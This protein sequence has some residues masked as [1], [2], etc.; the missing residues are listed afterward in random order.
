MPVYP[1]IPCRATKAAIQSAVERYAVRIGFRPGGDIS[2]TV[3]SLGGRIIYRD[4]FI[5]APGSCPESIHVRAADDFDIFVPHET[6][7]SRDRFTIAHE[8]GHLFLHYPAV[9][10]RYSNVL[11]VEMAATRY[12]PDAASEEI[13]RCEWEANWFAAAFLMP[14]TAFKDACSQEG[15]IGVIARRFLVSPSAVR[16]RKSSL[17]L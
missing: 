12:L 8:L 6:T 1:P 11:P 4:F 3:E 17:G 10:L 13:K 2:A 14:S 9:R 15:D 7:V 5:G 16:N